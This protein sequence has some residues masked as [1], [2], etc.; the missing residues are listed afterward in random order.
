MKTLGAVTALAAAAP[1][2]FWCGEVKA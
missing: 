2:T 1:L